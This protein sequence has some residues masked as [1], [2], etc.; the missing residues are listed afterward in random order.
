[1]LINTT[2]GYNYLYIR[3]PHFLILNLKHYLNFDWLVHLPKIKGE[4]KII[5]KHRS[6]QFT[7]IP[8]IVAPHNP[9]W[10]YQEH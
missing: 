9:Y 8:E 1:M 6:W 7:N 2:S 4:N 3:V 5:I 10:S